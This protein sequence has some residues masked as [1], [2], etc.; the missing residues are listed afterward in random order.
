MEKI[1]DILQDEQNIYM[2]NYI[3]Y[4]LEEILYDSLLRDIRPDGEPIL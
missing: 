1:T 2:Y 3:M 4:L